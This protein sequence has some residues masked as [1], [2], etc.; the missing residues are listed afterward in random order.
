MDPQIQH[1]L[2]QLERDLGELK[3]A[4]SNLEYLHKV[5]VSQLPGY[6]KLVGEER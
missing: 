4:V 3:T 2:E 6:K 1:R 5:F